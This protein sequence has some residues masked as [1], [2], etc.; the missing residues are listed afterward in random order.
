MKA[1]ILS[2]LLILILVKLLSSCSTA[3]KIGKGI[4]YGQNSR[5]ISGKLGGINYIMVTT[6]GKNK[7]P[8]TVD[9]RHD[10]KP[11]FAF[12]TTVLDNKYITWHGVTDTTNNIFRSFGAILVNGTSLQQRT[13]IAIS[14]EDKKALNDISDIL[15]GRNSHLT[16]PKDSINR[17]IGWVKVVEN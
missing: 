3:A 12:K 15:V 16:L 10:M 11:F 17:L 8:L 9:F 5:I 4:Y 7:Y 13:F 1:S 6:Q 2:Y 14:E